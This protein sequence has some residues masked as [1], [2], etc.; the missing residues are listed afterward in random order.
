M[1]PFI[2]LVVL[3][4]F[5]ISDQDGAKDQR[6]FIAL[7]SDFYIYFRSPA[8]SAR[9]LHAITYFNIN[10]N[11]FRI[12]AFTVY[13]LVFVSFIG[14]SIFV[15]WRTTTPCGWRQAHLHRLRGLVLMHSAVPGDVYVR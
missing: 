15:N 11:L 4:A 14:L 8:G 3:V 1:A 2:F 9:W 10:M 5:Q 7:Y 12:N 6:S 13:T